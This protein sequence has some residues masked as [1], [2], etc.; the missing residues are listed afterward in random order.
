MNNTKTSFKVTAIIAAINLSI[1]ALTEVAWHMT[2]LCYGRTAVCPILR[3]TKSGKHSCIA[4]RYR[5][6]MR[7]LIP[8]YKDKDGVNYL[9]DLLLCFRQFLKY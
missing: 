4:D 2:S 9:R 5:L 1:Y 3:C 6:C 8:I 7:R